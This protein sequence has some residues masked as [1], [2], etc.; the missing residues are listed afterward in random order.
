MPKHLSPIRRLEPGY[1]ELPC[2]LRTELV[3][4]TLT[5]GFFGEGEGQKIDGKESS[6]QIPQSGDSFRCV[7]AP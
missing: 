7:S 5:G 6:S 3:Q 1:I 4:L 2:H